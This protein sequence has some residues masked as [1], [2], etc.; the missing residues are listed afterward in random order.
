MEGTVMES[1]AVTLGVGSGIDTARLIADLAAASRAPK[2]AALD[3]RSSE[4]RARIS[5]LAQARSDL[6]SF[7]TSFSTLVAGG[8]LQSQP[9]VA[10]PLVIGAVAQPGARIGDLAAEIEVTQLAR[11]QTIYSGYV[12][13]ATAAIGQ[14]TMTLSIGGVDHAITIDASNDSLGGL[15]TAINAS[16]SGVTATISSDG[17]GSRLVLKGPVGAN[18]GFTLTNGGNVALNPFSYPA[19]GG[20]MTLAQA[21]QDAQ[22]KVD[23]IAYARTSNTV[24]DVFPGITLSL[25]Q[26]VPGRAVA[27][28]SNRPTA[29]IKSTLQD[30]VSVFNTMKKDLAAARTANRGDQGLRSLEQQL[31]AMLSRAVTSDP[32]INSL[33]DIGVATNRDGSISLDTAKLDAALAAKPDAVE[34]LLSPTRDA[35]RTALTDPGISGALN[36]LKDTAIAS[37]GVLASVKARLDREGG[38]IDKARERMEARETVYRDRL[39]RQFGGMDARVATLKATQSYLQQ[40]V[41]IWTKSG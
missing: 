32:A 18:G 7:A 9:S 11:S 6:E 33:S 4:N 34:A 5:A 21:A 37:G 40:Q 14:G 28:T 12:S 15:A 16:A 31:S 35:T 13:S 17:N 36:M 24:T 23:G 41:A 20:G 39:T 27:I 19:A 30:F 1:I 38:D 22:F 29:T 10:D 8:T 25:K 26:A 3:Q 2:V